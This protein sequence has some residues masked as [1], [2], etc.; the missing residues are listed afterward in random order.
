MNLR[1][2]CLLLITC[3][4]FAGVSRAA[5]TKWKVTNV[6]LTPDTER[7]STLRVAVKDSI[8]SRASEISANVTLTRVGE[9]F[10]S[11][12]KL[13]VVGEAGR[14]DEVVVFDLLARRKIDWFYCYYPQRLSDDWI[15]YV[16]FY[17]SMSVEVPTNVVLLYDLTKSPVDN[18]LT[19]APAETIPAPATGP[20]PIQVGIPIYPQ[21]NASGKSYANHVRDNSPPENVLAHTF[22]LLPPKRVIF[23]AAQ[24]E[25]F[26]N[27]HN[28]LV[29][30]DLSRGPA[31]V[32]YRNVEIPKDQLDRPGENPQFVQ[33]S[34]A[35]AVSADAVRL[36]VP[37]TDYGVDSIVVKIPVKPSDAAKT[38]E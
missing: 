10:V 38:T 7:A 9:Y 36:Y 35:E 23:V 32:S 11:G 31:N 18:R 21:L 24:G 29:V 1:T 6:T 2:A 19:R 26:P 37:R 22:V 13:A 8:H 28:Y 25:G 34:R 20:Q 3:I 14:A 30:V 4:G 16:E 12:D 27:P 33:V 5:P 15:A 17:P